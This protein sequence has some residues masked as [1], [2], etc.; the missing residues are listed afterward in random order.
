MAIVEGEVNAYVSRASISLL[1]SAMAWPLITA[2]A[3]VVAA[4]KW[5]RMIIFLIS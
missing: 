5:Y 1:V 2:Q 4:N 3:R